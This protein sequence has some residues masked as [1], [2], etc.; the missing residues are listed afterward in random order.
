MNV[1]FF[2]R[3]WSSN[4][5][6]FPSFFY[7]ALLQ[8]CICEVRSILYINLCM[9]SPPFT[10]TLHNSEI[11]EANANKAGLVLTVPPVMSAISSIYWSHKRARVNK[12]R[13]KIPM[14]F[15]VVILLLNSPH[16]AIEPL[17]NKSFAGELC[18]RLKKE[19]E[20][21]TS[22]ISLSPLYSQ[23]CLVCWAKFNI[24][25]SLQHLW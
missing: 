10:C 4:N 23:N 2:L 25:I 1:L 20:N 7:Y 5:Q 14:H 19:M 12:M 8:I 22:L 18:K 24:R 6:H 15:A 11:I 17:K 21:I 9:P 13:S 3:P 16:S